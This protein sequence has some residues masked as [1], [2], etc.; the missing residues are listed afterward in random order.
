[1][2]RALEAE[3]LADMGLEIFDLQKIVHSTAW[4]LSL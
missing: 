1:M 3:Y 2:A 4:V